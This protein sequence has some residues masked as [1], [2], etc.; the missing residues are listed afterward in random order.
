MSRRLGTV[1]ALLV[2][3]ALSG[4]SNGDPAGGLA[5]DVD[6]ARS[7]RTLSSLEQGLIAVQTI[8]AESASPSASELTAALQQRDPS[9]RYT[10]AP[11]GD[12]GI[13]QVQ[14]GGGGPVMLVGISGPP[15]AGRPP[16]YLAV[17]QGS[18]TALF[19]GGSQPPQ[20]SSAQPT[21]PG[22]GASPPEA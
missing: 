5:G 15:T 21:G 1:L 2:C 10:L 11:P 16:Q 12:V 9:N 7:A 3:L 8:G 19:Y 20:Y 22:W 4:C 13:V 6:K 17:W 14:G 18:G